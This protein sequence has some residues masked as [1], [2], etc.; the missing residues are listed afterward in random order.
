MLLLA[1]VVFGVLVALI[2]GHDTGVR[3]ALGN[4]SA[5]WIV[6]PF[7]AGTLYWRAWPAALAGLAV[8]LVSLLGFY[9][10]VRRRSTHHGCVP[11]SRIAAS[12]GGPR[13]CLASRGSRWP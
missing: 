6:L 5:P 11:R 4:T 10:A 2:K 9:V 3:D 8:T 1:G 12:V 7:V 13:C